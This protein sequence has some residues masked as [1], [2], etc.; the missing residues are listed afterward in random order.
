MKLD[1][2]SSINNITLRFDKSEAQ[3]RAFINVYSWTGNVKT[4]CA[5]TLLYDHQWIQMTKNPYRKE[6]VTMFGSNHSWLN[7]YGISFN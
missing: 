4:A 1:K 3:N 2:K 7:A 6:M 5:N